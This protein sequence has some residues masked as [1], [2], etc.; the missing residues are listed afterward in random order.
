MAKNHKYTKEHIDYISSICKGKSKIEIKD[1]FNS[2]F[3]TDVSLGSIRS[4]MDRNDLKSGMRGRVN[5]TTQFKK[6]QESWCK[7]M[8]GLNLGGEAGWFKKGHDHWKTLP[9][10]SE[11]VKE[12]E[13]WTKI[14][15]P[16][17]W[18][19]KHLHIW[20]KAYGDIP[21]G[22]VI[23]F[24]DG[25]KINVELDNLF[26]VAQRVMT[27]V[28]RRKIDSDHPEIKVA[29]HNLAELELAISDRLK[30]EVHS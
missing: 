7:G 9:V 11:S 20:R 15:Q 26:M 12:G 28:V 29:T 18:V 1:L 17:T 14:A 8:K 2:E 19:R 6:G 16:S 23:R 3:E 27:S 24:K 5:T 13:V 30:K 21:A 10:G 4:I 25:N 22:M